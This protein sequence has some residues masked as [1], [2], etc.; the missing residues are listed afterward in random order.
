[1]KWGEKDSG[2]CTRQ[3][4]YLIYIY[5]YIW[6]KLEWDVLAKRVWGTQRQKYIESISN[7][8]SKLLKFMYFIS[9]ACICKI[10]KVSNLFA[11][12]SSGQRNN[13]K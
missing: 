13:E 4:Y 2:E 1:M 9:D 10:L 6:A 12:R 7:D 3:A 5:I 8:E 11:T